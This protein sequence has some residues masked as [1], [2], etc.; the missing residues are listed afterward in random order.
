MRSLIPLLLLSSS[1][2]AQDM[3][4]SLRQFLLQPIGLRP[5]DISAIAD[6]KSV[7]R[8]LES[9]DRT[10]LVVF[11]IVRIAVPRS[12]FV[13][14]AA[15]FRSSLR[16][17]TRRRFGIFSD[18]AVAAD[19]AGLVVAHDD[20]QDL[21]HCQAGACKLKFSAATIGR[22]RAIIDSAPAEA[23]SADRSNWDRMTS[24]PSP[25]RPP[26]STR[27]ATTLLTAS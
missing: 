19:V 13:R 12:F 1:L 18:P 25:I 2:V 27:S 22:V 5:D 17:A 7:V 21:A 4:S 26:D 9:S 6:G 14:R 8:M 15:D 11:G 10:E 20:V 3:P 16:S 24:Q 23:D